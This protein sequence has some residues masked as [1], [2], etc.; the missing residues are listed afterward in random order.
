MT[1]TLTLNKEFLHPVFLLSPLEDILLVIFI[2][3]VF[4]Y[5][6]AKVIKNC[7]KLC[8]IPTF[9]HILEIVKICIF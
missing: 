4:L 7:F 6:V 5:P 3:V 8:K 9:F 1:L 2:S